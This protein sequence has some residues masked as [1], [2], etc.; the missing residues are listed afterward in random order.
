[1]AMRLQ[2]IR[3]N[4]AWRKPRSSVSR[5]RALPLARPL[6]AK[7]PMMVRNSWLLPAPDSPT[8]PTT[9]P[10]SSVNDTS[11]TALTSPSGVAKR[12]SRCLISRSDTST[13]LRVEGIAQPVADEV[14]REQRGREKYC[15]EDQHPG[16]GLH[17]CRPFA[18][19]HTPARIG[20]LH[21]EAEEGEEA[22]D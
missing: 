1:M 10:S 7:R 13:I 15:R 20:L 8:M 12:V 9:S 6:A 2:R 17:L 14:E 16:R 21:A 18:D 11:L 3:F 19:E 22:F 5:K 4:S